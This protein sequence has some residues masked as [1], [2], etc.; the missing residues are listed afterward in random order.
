MATL[1]VITIHVADSFL[2]QHSNGTEYWWV[3]NIYNS[4]SRWAV[5]VFI[6]VSGAL[7]LDP[8][9]Q[10]S[11]STFYRKRLSRVAIPLV[12][13]SLFFTIPWS[14][15]K[16]IIS[17]TPIHINL[18]SIFS[19]QPYYHLW[20]LYMILGLY[21]VTP[22]FR[23][24]TKHISTPMLLRLIIISFLIALINGANTN[25]FD[26]PFTQWFLM[27]IPYFLMGHFI[28]HTKKTPSPLILK[29]IFILSVLLTVIGNALNDT[30]YF[31][32]YL[33]ISVVPMSISLMY[34]F[35]TWKSPIVNKK[36]TMTLSKLSFGIYLI[37]PAV[38]ELVHYQGHPSLHI[39]PIFSIPILSLFGFCIALFG[40]YFI[41]KTPILRHVI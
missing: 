27:Y 37:H 11:M 12:F 30:T 21:M 38:L 9:K 31:Y 14:I 18:L 5:P 29:L 2:R 35:K 28:M 26:P 13:W 6:M 8:S 15:F 7:L 39:H 1:A 16:S 3:A 36:I 17:D 19:G 24:L 4:A 22:W 25:Y 20:F 10:E 33:S 32:G 34:L 41:S 23:I 40:A